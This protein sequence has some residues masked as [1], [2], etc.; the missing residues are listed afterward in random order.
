MRLYGRHEINARHIVVKFQGDSGGPLIVQ[1]PNGDFAVVGLTSWGPAV[2]AD[3]LPGVYTRVNQFLDWI[4]NI[5][6]QNS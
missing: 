6:T 4:N 3:G 5:I 2:C 1:E